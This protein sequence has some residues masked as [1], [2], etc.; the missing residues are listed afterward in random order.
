MCLHI[1]TSSVE[2]TKQK[3]NIY[4][5]DGLGKRNGRLF[6][7]AGMGTGRRG[8]GKL[9]G[10]WPK[11]TLGLWGGFLTLGLFI[12]DTSPRGSENK[13]CFRF[14]LFVFLF[15]YFLT[16]LCVFNIFLIFLKI[17]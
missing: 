2:S 3:P 9:P 15:V 14:V 10:L 6:E 11:C 17:F 4:S 5:F 8:Q 13:P 1:I 7:K 12:R 16:F